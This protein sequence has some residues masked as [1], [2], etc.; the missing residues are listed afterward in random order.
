MGVSI[1]NEPLIE[2]ILRNLFALNRAHHTRAFSRIILTLYSRSF[3]Y[4]FFL[5]HLPHAQ[6]LTS[7]KHPH[8]HLTSDSLD[9]TQIPN[10]ISSFAPH[11]ISVLMCALLFASHDSNM[12]TRADR[13]T[14]L[15]LR[16]YFFNLSSRLLPSSPCSLA[17]RLWCPR[18]GCNSASGITIGVAAMT[19]FQVRTLESTLFCSLRAHGR[20]SSIA[21]TLELASLCLGA[22]SLRACQCLR[23]TA[24]TLGKVPSF[25][26]HFPACF[27]STSIL[28]LTSSHHIVCSPA[29]P[30]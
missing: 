21:K 5:V 2:R 1:N 3:L 29:N 16:A 14:T 13:V 22:H 30:V 20:S 8:L 24:H 27:L 7:Y 23:S 25:Y 6:I 17:A 18:K 26:E 12:M 11:I 15:L 4:D 28:V 19:E 9:L 10:S